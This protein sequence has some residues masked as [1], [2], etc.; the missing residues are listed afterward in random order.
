[1]LMNYVEHEYMVES[2]VFQEDKNMGTENISVPP[3]NIPS[4]NN[5]KSPMTFLEAHSDSKD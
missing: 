4:S 2:T 5:N 1:M 3:S